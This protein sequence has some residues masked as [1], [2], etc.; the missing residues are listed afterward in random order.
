MQRR[1]I[2]GRLDGRHNTDNMDTAE[3]FYMKRRDACKIK[4]I[5]NYSKEDNM[6]TRKLVFYLI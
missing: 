6:I 5:H 3:I 1:E 4:Y 2:L